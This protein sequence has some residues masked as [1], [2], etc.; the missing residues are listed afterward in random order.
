MPRHVKDFLQNIFFSV[1]LLFFCIFFLSV[2]FS[3]S[4][5][6]SLYFFRRRRERTEVG[7]DCDERNCWEF[8][9]YIFQ[10]ST[11]FTTALPA[12]VPTCVGQF[13]R[14][15]CR[16]LNVEQRPKVCRD[17]R[18]ATRCRFTEAYQASVFRN[19]KAHIFQQLAHVFKTVTA[20]LFVDMPCTRQYAEIAT[21]D[22][23]HAMQ[24]V[25]YRPFNIRSTARLNIVYVGMCF[26]RNDDQ[27]LS[28]AIDGRCNVDTCFQQLTPI[29]GEFGVRFNGIPWVHKEVE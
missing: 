7:W 26:M 5:L 21:E 29:V 25:D 22:C 19:T 2:F 15:D 9:S 27:R 14:N 13:Q 17:I 23:I 28:R 3:H 8:F 20:I 24:R 11:S 18:Y 10:L 4:P 12:S 1:A 6:Y 16:L